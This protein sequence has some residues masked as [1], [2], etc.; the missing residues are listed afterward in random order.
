VTRHRPIPSDPERA[1]SVEDLRLAARDY[2]PWFAFE[3]VDSGSED[4]LTLQRNHAAFGEVSLVP[5]ALVDVAAVKLEVHLFG[6]QLA[7]PLAISPTGMNGLLRHEADL[8][9]ARAAKSA[10]I[11]MAVSTASNVPLETIAEKVGGRLWM[12]LYALKEA[13]AMNAILDR[14][15][16][17]GYEAA[18][19]TVDTPVAGGREWDARNFV[20]PA[21]L[22]LRNQ[23]EILAHP[24][25]MANVLRR[26][27]PRFPN[28]EAVLPADQRTGRAGRHYIAHNKSPSLTWDSVKRLREKWPRKLMLKGILAPAD[29]AIAAS[30]GVDAVIL[31]NHGGRQ[32]DASVSS[33]EMLPLCVAAAGRMPIL[34]DGGVRRGSDIVKAVALGA[35]AVMV[36]RPALYGVAAWGEAGVKRAIEIF[37][38]ET[39]RT[40]ALIGCAAMGKLD[41]S[42]TTFATDGAQAEKQP[43]AGIPR[44][45]KR[46]KRKGDPVE[47]LAA[48]PLPGD[49]GSQR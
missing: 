19:L 35:A 38:S 48:A 21:V 47:S 26:G 9:L 45:S 3:F 14:A 20:R 36:G 41:R 18:I 30:V 39:E 7:F 43:S 40:M 15:Q 32:L 24:G 6:K 10:G 22:T 2:L 4:E 11:P 44:R 16:A 17:A 31:S 5:R 33:F 34:L 1:I 25:W 12:Q 37:R 29:V 42:F 8:S 28:I 13:A 46:G 49:A 23:F 27:L